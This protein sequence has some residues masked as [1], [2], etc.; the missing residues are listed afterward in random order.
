MKKLTVTVTNQRGEIE[1]ISA[2]VEDE[3]AEALE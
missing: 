2:Y 1:L 3:I